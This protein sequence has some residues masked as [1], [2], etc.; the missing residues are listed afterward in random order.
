MATTAALITLDEYMST[1]YSPDCEYIDGV[2]VERNVG[3]GK[4]AFAQSKLLFRLAELTAGKKLIVL[5]EQRTRVARTRVRIPD[6]CVIDELKEV[7]TK[8]PLLCVEILSP[9]DRW[10]RVIAS[11]SDYQTMGVAC[12]WLIDPY[13]ANAWMFGSEHPP[14]EVKD[15]RLTAQSLG[16]EIQLT[17]VVP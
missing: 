3:Q 9:D 8:V 6:V 2:V 1:S 17:D 15:G 16:V 4:H 5:V 12:V 10:S 13:Q 7:V 11:V 14:V